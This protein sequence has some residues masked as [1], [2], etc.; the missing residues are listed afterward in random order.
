MRAKRILVRE[1]VVGFHCWPTPNAAVPY[2]GASHRHRFGFQVEAAVGHC[3]R[4][5]E[6]HMLQR[7]TREMVGAL[8]P[9]NAHIEYEFGA[10]S[11]EAIAE[12]VLEGLVKDGWPMLAVEVWEDDECGARVENT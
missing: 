11:C 5:V 1:V 9:C 4:E 6:F 10:R 7:A 8:F 2:L 3:D 12:E